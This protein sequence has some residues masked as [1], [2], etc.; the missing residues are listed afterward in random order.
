MLN[1]ARHE[2]S[3]SMVIELL[4]PGAVESLELNSREGCTIWQA[5][6]SPETFAHAYERSPL[7]AA[8]DMVKTIA[9]IRV[10][11]FVEYTAEGKTGCYPSGKDLQDLDAWHQVLG[12]EH[13]TRAYS[14]AFCGLSV[15]YQHVGAACAQC[16]GARAAPCEIAQPLCLGPRALGGLG[17]VPL[18]H[19]SPALAPATRGGAQ[20]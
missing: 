18:P 19:F 13:W 1:A 10:G 6:V 5:P 3:H 8:A 20:P 12:H 16:H 9:V 15:W 2:I 11:A 4:Y 7:V 14:A 17:N